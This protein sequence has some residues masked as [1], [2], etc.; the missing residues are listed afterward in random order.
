MKQLGIMAKMCDDDLAFR[1]Q[2]IFFLE[3]ALDFQH[4]LDAHMIAVAGVP[5]ISMR[6]VEDGA[7]QIFAL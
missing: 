1:L 5:R 4:R 3:L 2:D 7:I 6:A